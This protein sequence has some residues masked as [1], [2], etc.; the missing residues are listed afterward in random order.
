[1]RG[2]P[3]PLPQPKRKSAGIEATSEVATW[4][5]KQW[6]QRGLVASDEDARQWFREQDEPTVKRI[7]TA[8]ARFAPKQ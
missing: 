3:R 4:I 6:K 5:V 2:E 7:R 1:M 8:T